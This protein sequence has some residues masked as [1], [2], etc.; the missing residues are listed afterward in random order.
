M[1][2]NTGVEVALCRST[3]P[4]HSL[5]SAACSLAGLRTRSINFFFFRDTMLSPS[6]N[7]RRGA[8]LFSFSVAQLYQLAKNE[9]IGQCLR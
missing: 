1:P 8:R 2:C 7:L 6:G 5:V 3:G 4:S 9:P